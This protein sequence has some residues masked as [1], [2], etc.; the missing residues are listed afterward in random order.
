MAADELPIS[1]VDS[2]VVFD[3]VE[4]SIDSRESLNV[5]DTFAGLDVG[6]DADEGRN[7]VRNSNQR[8]T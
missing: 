1:N 6:V 5:A 8:S 4:V 3:P 7:T 2:S